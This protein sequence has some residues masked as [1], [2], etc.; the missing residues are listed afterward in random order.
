[1][2]DM[3]LSG[4]L[5]DDQ[6][7]RILVENVHPTKMKKD[8]GKY[9]AIRTARCHGTMIATR[10]LRS[11]LSASFSHRAQAYTRQ[12]SGSTSWCQ[13]CCVK[14]SQTYFLVH[15]PGPSTK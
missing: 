10:N 14:S 3:E 8:F 1:M 7:D 4:L 13:P 11:R 2:S 12:R 15:P 9:E 6:D 5:P